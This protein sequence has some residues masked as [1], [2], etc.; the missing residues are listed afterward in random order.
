MKISELLI[1]T[2]IGEGVNDPHIFKAISIIGPMGAGK[3]TIAR[4]LVGGTGLRSL[5]LDNFNELFIKQGKVPSGLISPDQ[6][7]RSWE[8]TQ[9]Q[10][11][12][13]ITNR[14]GLL[15]DGSGR[16]VQALHKSLADLEK[17]GYDT[18]VILIMASFNTL[19]KRQQLRIT[20]QKMQF[21]QGRQIPVD[22][23]R[24]SYDQIQLNITKL[25]QL[26]GDRL[27][28]I[29]NEG[30]VDLSQEQKI[31]DKFLS[32]PP[33]KPAAQEWIKAHS[34]TQGQ[35]VDKQIAQ[36]QRKT[37]SAARAAQYQQPKE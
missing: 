4:Q 5:N 9:K 16:N 13:W 27:L 30:A 18:L 15:V 24:T 34:Q 31:V 7:Q 6:L 2:A 28:V 26:Y 10:K 22:L 12:N 8:L 36:Q 23:A 21:G 32:A 14:L 29:N 20:Q 3:S 1:E 37:A 11:G 25:K 35:R 17:L 19:L 33:L